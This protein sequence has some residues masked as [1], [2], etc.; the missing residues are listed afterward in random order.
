MQGP[1][2]ELFSQSDF[3]AYS[4][5]FFDSMLNKLETDCYTPD[6][7]LITAASERLVAGF[8]DAEYFQRHVDVKDDFSQVVDALTKKVIK[9]QEKEDTSR[10]MTRR[11]GRKKVYRV[12]VKK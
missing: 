9:A 2:P 7:F 1:P 12:D 11:N 8:D 5:L 6:P 10:E 3:D 4:S